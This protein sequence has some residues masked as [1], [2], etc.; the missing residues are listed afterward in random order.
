MVVKRR[1]VLR[2]DGDPSSVVE[3]PMG[4]VL[5]AGKKKRKKL[6]IREDRASGSKVV[7]SEGGEA[8][9]PLALLA[10]GVDG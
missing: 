3:I 1:D 8:L 6:R 10:R 5:E 9:D 2:E 7:F 4:A